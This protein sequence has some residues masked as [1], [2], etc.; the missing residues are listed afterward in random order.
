[1]ELIRVNRLNI[2]GRGDGG[3]AG[4]GEVAGGECTLSSFCDNSKLLNIPSLKLYG[5]F[6]WFAK[7]QLKFNFYMTS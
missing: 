6:H 4:G 7:I 5:I 3:G 1:M 2:V